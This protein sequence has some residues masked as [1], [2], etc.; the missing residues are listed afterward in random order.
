M[1]HVKAQKKGWSPDDVR[2]QDVYEPSEVMLG[3]KIY[4][5]HFKF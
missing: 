1:L 3:T 4:I 2:R 5:L